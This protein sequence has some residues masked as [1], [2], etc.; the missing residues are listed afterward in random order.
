MTVSALDG[1]FI[2]EV[3]NRRE[4]CSGFP[5]FHMTLLLNLVVYIRLP[6]LLLD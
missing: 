5:F 4:V 1:F 3:T 6:V 2:V